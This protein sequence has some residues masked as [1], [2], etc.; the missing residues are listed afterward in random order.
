MER[1]RRANA[2]VPN[3]ID[4]KESPILPLELD[5]FVIHTARRIHGS[6]GTQK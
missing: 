2:L 5:L 3:S 4:L 1:Y 6:V